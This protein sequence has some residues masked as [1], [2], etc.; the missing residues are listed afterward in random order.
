MTKQETQMMKGVAI[1]L[2]LFLHLFNQLANVD[3]CRNLISVDGV[4]LVYILSRVA[5][6]VPF[7]LIL[8]GYGLFIVNQR[9]DRH[10]WSRILKLF[11]HYWIILAVFVTIGH[12]MAPQRYPRS[13]AYLILNIT[14]IHT[15]YNGEMW[16]LFP[17]V[18]LSLLSPWII[19]IMKRFKAWQII[20]VTLFIHLCTS[21]CISRY[22][23]KYLFPNYW[24]Y[25]LLLVFHLLFAFSLGCMAARERFFEKVKNL[26]AGHRYAGILKWG[27]V[28]LLVSVSCVFK[29]NFFYAILLITLLV[30]SPLPKSVGGVLAKLGDQSMNMWMIHSWF[31]YNL[32]HDFIYSF[33]YP[34]LIFVVLTVISYCCSLI[35]NAICKPVESRILPK[36]E[37]KA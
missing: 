34:I 17:Y 22:G 23:E 18:V 33:S 11:I 27:G 30:M 3:L 5:N 28:I 1:L 37:V 4:P 8:S 31:C 9:G 7:F 10:R 20:A 25:N 6:P 2:M 19:R 14:S 32:F 36:A 29:Y 21:F 12:F 35:I 13:L 15:T 26:V 16:F 24:F